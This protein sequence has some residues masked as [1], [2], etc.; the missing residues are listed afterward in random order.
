M[1]IV[2]VCV[3]G[4]ASV[5]VYGLLVKFDM[6]ETKIFNVCAVI[7]G[8]NECTLNIFDMHPK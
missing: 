4:R 8:A 6:Q 7:A 3:C 5:Y 2:C 1:E